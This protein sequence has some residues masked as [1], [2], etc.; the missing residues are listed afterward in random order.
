[1]IRI[2]GNA[3]KQKPC[4]QQPGGLDTPGGSLFQ[5]LHSL[6]KILFYSVAI[7]ITTPQIVFGFGQILRRRRVEP[8]R[9]PHRITLFEKSKTR[10]QLSLCIPGTGFLQQLIAD[11]FN[12]FITAGKG[13][14]TAKC[15]GQQNFPE[16]IF[17]N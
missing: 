5:I 8:V 7:Q 12:C 4:Q 14:N 1:M 11:I 16:Q 2:G 15:G 3:G 13:D 9:R 17:H 10:C 6:M